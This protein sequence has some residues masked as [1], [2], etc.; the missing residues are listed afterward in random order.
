MCVC[1]TVSHMLKY[2]GTGTSGDPSISEFMFVLAVDEMEVIYCDASK[3]ILEPRQDW[4]KK[5]LDDNPGALEDYSQQCFEH[6]PGIYQNSI[7]NL[8]QLFNQTEG[9]VL[10][11]IYYVISSWMYLKN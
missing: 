7:S 2:F 3:K 9:A 1:P 10:S 8:K 5:M 6:Q 4:V 11:L